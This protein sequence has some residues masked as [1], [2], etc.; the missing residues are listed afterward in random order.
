MKKPGWFYCST[1]M[2]NYWYFLGWSEKSFIKYCKEK[3]NYEPGDLKS[4]KLIFLTCDKG[5]RILIWTKVKSDLP[6]FVH[7]CVHAATF[8]LEAKGWRPDFSNDEP[9]T[10]LVQSIFANGVKHTGV[11]Y[12]TR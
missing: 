2:M 3:F 12:D 5:T 4:G 6:S 9:L 8:T 7:E 1:W 11:S 10:Y